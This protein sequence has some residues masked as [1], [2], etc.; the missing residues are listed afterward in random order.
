MSACPHL[1]QRAR[2]RAPVSTARAPLTAPS[3][4]SAP[5]AP[6]HVPRHAL[7]R[8]PARQA[9]PELRAPGVKAWIWA[10]PLL[11]LSPHLRSC[12]STIGLPEIFFS[13]KGGKCFKQDSAGH[14]VHTC[15]KPGHSCWRRT[16]V[17]SKAP[18]CSW[19]EDD[20]EINSAN[21]GGLGL[22]S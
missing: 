4:V 12:S 19:M 10:R 9:R 14:Y 7:A 20:R 16:I 11:G 1:L 21:R 22:Q 15:T 3:P 8:L 13:V 2:V 5:C 6:A 17:S 18:S